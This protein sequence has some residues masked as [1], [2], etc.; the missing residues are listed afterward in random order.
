MNRKLSV[1]SKFGPFGVVSRSEVKNNLPVVRSLIREGF[2]KKVYKK[3]RVFYEL[4]DQTLP[5]LDEFRNKLL[6]EARLNYHLSPR[7]RHFY[8][9]LL[10]DVRFL[11]DSAP[12]A[13]DFR[14]L[15]D[16]RLQE[17]PLPAQLELAQWR[18]Y[19]ARGL[20]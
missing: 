19:Q 17:P 7:R 8:G 12:D 10:D 16:W 13:E 5:M 15:G 4:T 9:P 20:A 1:F 2:V 3:G 11:D 18:Y 14:F 6:A